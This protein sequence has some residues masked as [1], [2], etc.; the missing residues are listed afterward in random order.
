MSGLTHIAVDA[1]GGDLG[2][3]VTVP[4]SLQALARNQR[5]YIHLV[6]D[7]GSIQPLLEGTAVGGLAAR[8][9]VNHTDSLVQDRD[10]PTKVLREKTDSS[11][12]IAVA[13]VRDGVVQACV[14]AGNT[15]ALLL[16]GRHLLKT[17]P[18]VDKPAIVA[19]IPGAGT[20]AYLLDVGANL[21]CRAEQLFQ[22][23]VMGSALAQSLDGTNRPRIALLNIGVED[24]KGTEQVKLAASM[25][26]GCSQL[27][28][29]GYVEG[30]GVFDGFADVVVCDGFAG[31]VTIK[32][33][34]GV[35][36]VIDTFLTE[37]ALAGRRNRLAALVS[38]PLLRQLRQRI[39][40][41]QYNG[42]SLLGLQGTIIKSHGA[43]TCEG[44]TCAILRAAREAEAGVPGLVRDRVSS[45]LQ[46]G[47][48]N[49]LPGS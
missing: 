9:S 15:G 28:Y 19:T 18:G 2:P 33:S 40:P 44:F 20:N 34:A 42:A 3:P 23:A 27:N 30:S 26:E 29:A 14:S 37:Q 48:E 43:A 21:D 12:F 10:H 22:F 8:L 36:K 13:M 46:R 17:I 35:I 7:S 39:D 6:G 31:N 47:C 5:L 4:A 16:S 1:M 49:S 32:S 38:A 41:S 25:L 11:M 45:L 24:Y